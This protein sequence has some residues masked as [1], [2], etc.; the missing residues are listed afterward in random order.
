MAG[1]SIIKGVIVKCLFHTRLLLSL[2]AFSFLFFT[3]GCSEPD[4]EDNILHARQLVDEANDVLAA[5]LVDAVAN[6]TDVNLVDLSEPYNIYLDALAEDGENLEANF[7]A[8]MLG[9]QMILRDPAI[10]ALETLMDEFRVLEPFQVGGGLLTRARQLALPATAPL[11][12]AKGLQ[13]VGEADAPQFS[14]IQDILRLQILPKID[15]SVSRL[16]KVRNSTAFG[17]TITPAMQGDPLEDPIVLDRTE[18]RATLAVLHVLKAIIYQVSAYNF[19]MGGYTGEDLLAAFTQNSPYLAL[20]SHGAQDMFNAGAAWLAALD[21][22]E[23]A[24]T[25]LRAESITQMAQGL[26]KIDPYSEDGPSSGELDELSAGLQTARQVLTGS[27]TIELDSISVSPDLVIHLSSLF[28]SPVQN[29]KAMLPA[30]TVDLVELPTY[31]DWES[32]SFY[33]EVT[34]A[35]PSAGN[36]YW[37]FEEEY[38]HG[39]LLYSGRWSSFESS[40]VDSLFNSYIE[41]FIHVNTTGYLGLWGSHTFSGTEPETFTLQMYVNILQIEGYHHAVEITWE[42]ESYEDWIFPNPTLNGLLPGMTDS[43]LKEQ[44]GMDAA[45]WNRSFV[46]DLYDLFFQPYF[47]FNDDH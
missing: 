31:G 37:D 1:L 19:N 45:E 14:E 43:L 30:Y 23:G 41:Q 4:E 18:V 11:Q 6:Q 35:A 16:Q 10:E 33:P 28:S 8:G 17:F 7:G 22:L 21:A 13:K 40:Q 32:Y 46:V 25:S 9:L 26:I 47:I 3:I 27:Y 29:W 44:I 5:V 42:A 24:V 12:I 36:Y 39:E 34:V 20:H 38:N 15:L 2:F